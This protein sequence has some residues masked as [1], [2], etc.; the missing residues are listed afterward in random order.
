MLYQWYSFRAVDCCYIPSE[1]FW[2]W[3]RSNAA[4]RIVGAVH[5]YASPDLDSLTSRIINLG[6]NN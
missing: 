6:V 4:I 5:V 3:E 2:Y 1:G